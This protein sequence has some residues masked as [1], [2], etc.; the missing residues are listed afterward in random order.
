MKLVPCDFC[1]KETDVEISSSTY[2]NGCKKNF[3]STFKTSCFSDYHRQN[4]CND[5]H[6]ITITNPQWKV[7]LVQS[8]K[9]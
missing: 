7:N 3:C 4:L 9:S 6:F 1:G 5:P 2:C 8:K